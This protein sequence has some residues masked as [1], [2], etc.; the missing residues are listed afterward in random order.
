MSEQQRPAGNFTPRAK[1]A[2]DEK[3]LNLEGTLLQGATRN[4]TWSVAMIA[5][6]LR[7]TCYSN[8]PNDKDNG[9]IEAKMSSIA[10][11]AFLSA[12]EYVIGHDDKCSFP[13]EC[14]TVRNGDW[15]NP[16]LESTLY[17]GRNGEGVI[18]VG[19]VSADDS[20]P[21]L[22]FPMRPNNFH[23]FIDGATKSPLGEKLSSQFWASGYL[24]LMRNLTSSV[25][26]THF[27]EPPP[28]PQGG[29][30]GGGNFNRSGGG[31]GGYNRG[32]G[33]GYNRG[34]NGGGGYNRNGGGNNNYNRGGQSQ[35]QQAAPQQSNYA[36]PPADF[37]DGIPF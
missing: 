9:R 26:D 24:H 6:Q 35:P 29:G 14:Y 4:P 30:N 37:D 27:K 22:N 2:L 23:A 13:F 31:G 3:K 25:L 7:V 21:R 15:K 32:G 16:V 17:V 20:R 34:G 10:M 28:R 8:L 18:Y 5:N 19:I 1:N 33:G 12:L 11:H 36:P